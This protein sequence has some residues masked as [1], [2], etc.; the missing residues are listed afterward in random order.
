MAK[1]TLEAIKERLLSDVNYTGWKLISS[2]YSNLD[3]DLIFECP[4]GHKVY[5]SWKKARNKLVCP[6][7]REKSQ[8]FIASIPRKKKENF[9]ILALDQATKNTGWSLFDGNDLI[10]YGIF[11]TNSSIEELKIKEIK[12][13]LINVIESYDPDLVLLEDI[14]Y[15]ARFEDSDN[16]GNGI[17]GVTTFKILAH[18]QGVLI[19]VLVERN[20]NHQV[21]SPSSW[22]AELKIKG[23]HRSDKKRAAQLLV[24]ERYGIN[25]LEDEADAICIGIFGINTNQK[26]RQM[27][28]W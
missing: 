24:K 4:C 6:I 22:R 10:R 1:I 28:T 23:K 17:V 16:D 5:T 13:W 21:V 12:E 19:N 7:C 2:E 25:P 18:L 3:S 20:L 9:R 27:V 11:T 14:H 26:N 8:K 15:Q